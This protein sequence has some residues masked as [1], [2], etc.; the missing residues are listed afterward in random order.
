M[1]LDVERFSLW[2]SL[3]YK[4]LF[5]TFSYGSTL[6]DKPKVLLRAPTGVPAVNW[7]E[8]IITDEILMISNNLLF[9]V[10]LRLNEVF[11]TNDKPFAGILVITVC[12][13]L[14]G[15]PTSICHFFCWPIHLSVC[16]PIDDHISGTVHHVIIIFGTR[17]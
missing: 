3:I 1:I 15:A 6:V 16:P 7:S 8:N 11:G 2:N 9:Y 14:G 10:H 12:D 17:V 13:F 5:K 4:F